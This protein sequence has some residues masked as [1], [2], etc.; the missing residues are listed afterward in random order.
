MRSMLSG[1][2]SLSDSDFM[3]VGGGLLARRGILRWMGGMKSRR[4][5]QR[6]G[7]NVRQ[8]EKKH[9]RAIDD[10]MSSQTN[11]AKELEYDQNT[12]SWA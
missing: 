9:Q 10:L 4:E 1:S 8:R 11:I 12:V 3:A 5:S 7:G 6:K 2:E